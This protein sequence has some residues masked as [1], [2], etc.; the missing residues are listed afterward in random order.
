[1]DETGRMAFSPNLLLVLTTACQ[2]PALKSRERKVPD[3]ITSSLHMA[4]RVG[5]VGSVKF[6]EV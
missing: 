6:L 2:C 3:I 4:L 1:M 5:L